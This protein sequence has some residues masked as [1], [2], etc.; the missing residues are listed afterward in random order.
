MSPRRGPSDSYPRSQNRGLH[1]TNKDLFVGTPDLERAASW[2]CAAG[3][4]VSVGGFA[5]IGCRTHDF[6][7][8]DPNYREYAYVTNA[9]S[10]TVSVYDV[11]FVCVAREIPVGQIFLVVVVF[12]VC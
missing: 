12:L 7:Q 5:L 9:G 1:P 3:I 8:Y 4:S 10:G 11:V 6:P 2:K